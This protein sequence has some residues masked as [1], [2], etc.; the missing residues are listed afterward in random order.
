MSSGCK[1]VQDSSVFCRSSTR[2]MSVRANSVSASMAVRAVQ[3]RAWQSGLHLLALSPTPMDSCLGVSVFH[4][5]LRTTSIESVYKHGPALTL[6]Q[7][8]VEFNLTINLAYLA[9]HY[10]TPFP[11]VHLIRGPL[12]DCSSRTGDRTDVYTGAIR[13]DTI[14][15]ASSVSLVS[16]I[17]SHECCHYLQLGCPACDPLS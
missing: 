4:R 6:T 8:Q 14:N 7:Q 11:L 5:P 1:S 15:T 17:Q 12:H 16:C 9:F 10:T 2:C 3:K 13:Y